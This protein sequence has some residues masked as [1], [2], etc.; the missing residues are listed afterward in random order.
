MLFC[1][2]KESFLSSNELDELSPETLV[3]NF[4]EVYSPP[5]YPRTIGQGQID[6]SAWLL[7]FE[8]SRHANGF[9]LMPSSGNKEEDRIWATQEQAIQ[10][11]ST[12]EPLFIAFAK[13]TFLLP[14]DAAASAESQLDR[15]DVVEIFTSELGVV[16]LEAVSGG[17]QLTVAHRQKD[18]SGQVSRRRSTDSTMLAGQDLAPGMAKGLS[19]LH[20]ACEHIPKAIKSLFLH[21]GALTANAVR[22][23]LGQEIGHHGASPSGSLKKST[24]L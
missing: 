3:K 20:A 10:A 9:F 1:S 21:D 7:M 23:L 12:H 14:S 16:S 5:A 17:F 11:I 4:F 13:A 19:P 2:Q 24:G 15:K 22:K 6:G 18:E 8:A